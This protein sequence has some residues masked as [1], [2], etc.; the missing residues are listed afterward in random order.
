[1]TLLAAVA[2]AVAISFS[3]IFF[4]LSEVSP[5]TGAFYRAAYALPVLAFLWWLRRDEDRRST[6]NRWI[7]VAAGLALGGDVVAWHAS[8]ELIG[9]GLATLLANS[10][11]IFVAVAAWILQKEK[12]NR[13]SIVAIPVVLAGVAMVSGVG[14]ESAFGENPL[15]GTALALLAAMLYATFLLA[16]RRSNDTQA[17]GA[18]P[19][20]EATLGALVLALVAGGLGSGI[21]FGFTIPAHAWLMAL[22]LGSQVIGWLLIGYALPRLPAAETATI[23]LFQPALTLVWGALIFDERPSAIQIAGVVVVLAGVATVVAAR[24]RATPSVA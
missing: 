14:Q 9:A 22:A 12:P 1:M 11:V 13:A 10:Q 7:A 5:V 16:F 23:I 19:L 6:R 17:P 24:A 3:A 15:L 2:G 8:I 21:D 18:G 20:A 4:G